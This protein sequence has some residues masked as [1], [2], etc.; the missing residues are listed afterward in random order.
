V[1]CTYLLVIVFMAQ[2]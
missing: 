1:E 2:G